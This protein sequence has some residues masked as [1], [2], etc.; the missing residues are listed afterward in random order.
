MITLDMLLQV[1]K[2]V[3]QQAAPFTVAA[4]HAATDCKYDPSLIR[5]AIWYMIDQGWVDITQDRMFV[6]LAEEA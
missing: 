5:E 3:H 4:I 1:S 2:A 6:C